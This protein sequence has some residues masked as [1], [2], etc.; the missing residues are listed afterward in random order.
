[1]ETVQKDS[2]G[3]IATRIPSQSGDIDRP[4]GCRKL[5]G[6]KRPHIGPNGRLNRHCSGSCPH[7]RGS[8]RHPL[9]RN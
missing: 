3:R 1:M 7:S 5:P 2:V 4:R 9:R 8:P 6:F